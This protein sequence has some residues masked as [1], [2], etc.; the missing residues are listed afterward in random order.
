MYNIISNDNQYIKINI[1][2]YF[3]QN[4]QY[5]D[6]NNYLLNIIKIYGSKNVKLNQLIEK[7]I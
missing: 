7:I 1:L 2:K 5:I 4:S 3:C 6:S